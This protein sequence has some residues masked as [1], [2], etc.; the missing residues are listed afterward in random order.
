METQEILAQIRPRLEAA[1]GPRLKG[2]VLHGS[3]ARGEAQPDSDIDIMVLLDEPVSFFKDLQIITRVLYPLQ[4]EVPDRPLHAI[5]VSESIY[6]AGDFA[7]YRAAQ[8]EGVSL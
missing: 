1:F 5:P 8:R 6:R 4:L 7:A 2:I 3:E